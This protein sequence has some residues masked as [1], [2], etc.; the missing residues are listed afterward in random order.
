MNFLAIFLYEDINW[1]LKKYIFYGIRFQFLQKMKIHKN[2][3][4]NKKFVK[5]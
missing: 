2:C 3:L 5:R 4:I 1:L